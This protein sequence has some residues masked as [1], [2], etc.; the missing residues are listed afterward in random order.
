MGAWFCQ[1]INIVFVHYVIQLGRAK[2]Y[3]GMYAFSM[4]L[5][6]HMVFFVM[7]VR[8]WGGGMLGWHSQHRADDK[9]DNILALQDK[10]FLNIA[11][12]PFNLSSIYDE[13]VTNIVYCR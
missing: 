2:L 5:V 10:I 3:T 9:E 4:S 8:T 12:G 1:N 13:I 11:K 7:F 6:A